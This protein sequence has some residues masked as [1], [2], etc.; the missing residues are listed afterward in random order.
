[1]KHTSYK[2]SHYAVFS[3]IPPFSSLS[4]RDEVPYPYQTAGESMVSIF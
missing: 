4:V 1:L 2:V 3:S